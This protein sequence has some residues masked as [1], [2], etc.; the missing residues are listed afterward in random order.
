MK[1]AEIHYLVY[2]GE[3]RNKAYDTYGQ[4]IDLLLKDET[5]SILPVPRTVK[6]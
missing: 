2:L 6:H 3:V 5:I 4:N 1:E